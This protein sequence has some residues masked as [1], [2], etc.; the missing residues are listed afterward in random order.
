VARRA[1]LWKDGESASGMTNFLDDV[2]YEISSFRINF[3]KKC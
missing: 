2:I 3:T 1:L